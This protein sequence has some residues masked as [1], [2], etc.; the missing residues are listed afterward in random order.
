MITMLT[1]STN[2]YLVAVDYYILLHD[3]AGE[4]FTGYKK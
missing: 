4:G 2:S 3:E 1:K